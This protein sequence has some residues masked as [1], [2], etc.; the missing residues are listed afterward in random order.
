M[1]IVRTVAPIVVF[2]HKYVIEK[3][4]FSTSI[5]SFFSFI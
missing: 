5:Q 4:V 1:K 3:H 2:E